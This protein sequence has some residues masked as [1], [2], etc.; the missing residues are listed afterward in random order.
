MSRT[1]KHAALSLVMLATPFFAV[2]CEYLASNPL[3]VKQLLDNPVF[4]LV[5]TGQFIQM[6]RLGRPVINEALVVSNA[7]LNRW[8]AI[9]PNQDLSPIAAPIRAE[10]VRTLKAFGNS[11][12]RIAQL[13]AALLPDVMRIDTTIPSFYGTTEPTKGIPI[14]G[15]KITDD[16]VDIT[17]SLVIPAAAPAGLKTDNVSYA[18]PNAG[19]MSHKPLLSD[20]P[21]LAMPN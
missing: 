4:S 21:Y 3:L 13:T 2:G 17:L 9:M 19:G 20:F 12:A 15:R 14:G 11:D 1:M 16:V 8:N 5:G 7:L 18:G 10:A 6:E